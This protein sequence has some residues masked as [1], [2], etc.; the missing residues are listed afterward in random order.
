MRSTHFSL[1]VLF[2]ILLQLLIIKPEAYACYAII[3]GKDATADGSVML[4]HSELNHGQ[5]FLNFNIVPRMQFEEGEVVKLYHG[6]TMPQVE[7]T[8]RFMWSENFGSKGSDACLNEHGVAIVSDGT[9]TREGSYEELVKS[10]AIKHGGIGFMM[11][12]LVAQRARTAKEGVKL[13]GELMEN[14]GY[15]G[16]GVTFSIADPNEAWLVSVVRGNQWVAQRVP[17]NKVVVLANV[18]LI[19]EVNL[20]DT[21]NFLGSPALI[22][23]AIEKGWYEPGTGEP[24]N[25]SKAYDKRRNSRFIKK[26]HCDPR[27]WRGQCLVTGKDIPLP[28][29]DRLPFAVKPHKKLTIDDM[30]DIMSDHLEGTRFDQS[31]HYK[32]GSPHD[33]MGSGDGMICH[34]A[35]QEAAVFQLRSGLP[36]EIGCVY[37]RTTAASCSSVLTPWYLGVN[38]ISDAYHYDYPKEPVNLKWHFDPPEKVWQYNHDK[39]FWVFNTLENLTDLNYRKHI[40]Q[41]RPVWEVFEKKQY[42]N[43]QAIEQTALQLWQDDKVKAI[44]F[45]TAYCNGQAMGAIEKAKSLIQKIRTEEFGF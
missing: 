30:R 26:Y 1:T 3:A 5:R 16:S 45:L 32:K 6:G 27:Q 24:F 17:D 35:N 38:E 12:I 42:T 41:V 43:Q 13:I 22:D 19:N 15:D 20:E 4:A 29:N 33:L 10:G 40:K 31:D 7:E 8:Y 18:N 21:N 2:A 39:T 34:Q 28:I 11:R 37:W 14:F 36:K 9:H 23:H 44:D 25:F